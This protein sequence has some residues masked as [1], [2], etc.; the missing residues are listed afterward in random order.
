MVEFSPSASAAR[1]S[2]VQIPGADMAP[3]PGHAEVASRM[4]QPEALT[5]RVYN[6][7]LGGLGEKKKKKKICNRC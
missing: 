3:L 7:V 6:Y 2:M 4:P 1:V 5:A